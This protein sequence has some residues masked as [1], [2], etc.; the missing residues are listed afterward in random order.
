M[1]NIRPRLMLQ[2]TIAHFHQETEKKEVEKYIILS[3]GC[4]I[5]FS[6][7]ESS[8]LLIGAKKVCVK[9]QKELLRIDRIAVEL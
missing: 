7:V 2:K 1:E 4:N 6:K 3:I 5:I 8:F 9:K